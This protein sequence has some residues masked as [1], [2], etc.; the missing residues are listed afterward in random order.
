MKMK[1]ILYVFGSDVR[2]HTD[3]DVEKRNP[4][5]TPATCPG[6]PFLYA[7]NP[8]EAFDGC[9]ETQAF[10]KVVGERLGYQ[11]PGIAGEATGFP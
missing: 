1:S 2:P 9:L 11:F 7:V 4:P 5:Q 10:K 8:F 6:L 3:K